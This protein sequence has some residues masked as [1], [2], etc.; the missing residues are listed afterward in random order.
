MKAA[1][2]CP[3]II[4]VFLILTVNGNA[5]NNQ[6]ALSRAGTDT[7]K[8]I[9]STSGI[10]APGKTDSLKTTKKEKQKKNQEGDFNPYQPYTP[11]GKP[12]PYNTYRVKIKQPDRTDS[13]GGEILKAILINNIKHH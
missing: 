9:N 11:D 5:Q 8:K 3:A 2:F 12:L 1:F 10:A 7:L 4:I 13:L 6:P